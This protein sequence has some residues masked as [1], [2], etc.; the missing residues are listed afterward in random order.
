[1][2][3]HD[4]LILALTQLYKKG[5]APLYEIVES[6]DVNYR[7]EEPMNRELPSGNIIKMTP[8]I[9]VHYKGSEK[10]VA[11]EVENDIQWDFADSLRQVKKYKRYPPKNWKLKVIV[12]IPKEYQRFAPLYNNEEIPVWLWTATRIWECMRCGNI[13]EEKRTLK[14]KC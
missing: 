8:D 14:P 3:I 4:E 5:K 11:I 12:I 13:T 6:K 10:R 1:M 9:I 2:T 7:I